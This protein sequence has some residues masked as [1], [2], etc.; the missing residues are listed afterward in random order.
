MTN[1]QLAAPDAAATQE[2]LHPSGRYFADSCDDL[3]RCGHGDTGE[4]RRDADGRLIAAMWNAY[5][6]GQLV[7]RTEPS[8]ADVERVARIIDPSSWA[9]MD[10][11]LERM[12]RKYRGQHIGWPAD[13]FQHKESMALARA[14][15][16]AMVR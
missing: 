4:F 12:L 3:T 13:Q 6:A 2:E 7:V 9:V 10:G 1:E 14:A 5:R 15:I 8:E 16:A 11:E